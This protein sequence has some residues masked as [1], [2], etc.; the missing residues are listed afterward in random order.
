MRTRS[1]SQRPEESESGSLASASKEAVGK[2]LKRASSRKGSKEKGQQ[3]DPISVEESKFKVEEILKEKDKGNVGNAVGTISNKGEDVEV[4]VHR[5][6]NELEWEDGNILASESRESYSHDSEKEITVELTDFP[7]TTQRKTSRRATAEEKELA[8][9]VHKVHLLCLLSR[10]RLVDRVCNDPLIQASLLSLLPPSLLEIAEI[11]KLTGSTLGP[12]VKWFHNNF[13]LRSHDVDRGSFKSNLAFA[14]ESRLGTAEEVTALSVALFRALNLT[15]RFLSVL[16]VASLKP[17]RDVLGCSNPDSP[18]L[19]TNIFSSAVAS[20]SDQVSASNL[21]HPLPSSTCS[22]DI[23]HETLA[24][25]KH[26]KK[27]GRPIIKK[28]PLKGSASTTGLDIV[29]SGDSIANKL[30]SDKLESLPAKFPVGSKRKGDAEFE[31]QLEMAL[32]ATAAGVS[33]SNLGSHVDELSGSSLLPSPPSKK[34]KKP[35]LHQHESVITNHGSSSAVWSQKL[36]PPTYWAEVYCSG[37]TLNGRWVHVDAVNG[38]VDGESNVEAAAA[39]GRKPLKYV[40]AFSGGGAK[41]VTRRYCMHW[42]KIAPRRVNSQWWDEVLAP[43][44]LLESDATGGMIRMEASNLKEMGSELPHQ[45]CLNPLN[46]KDDILEGSYKKVATD[47]SSGVATRNSLEDMELDTR[48]LTEPLPTNQLAYKNH[49]LYVLE[50]WLTKYQFLHPKGPVLGHCSGHPVYPRSCVQ[51]LQTR[52]KWLRE[53]LQ[54]IANEI[55]AKVV[56]HSKKF[57]KMQRSEDVSFPGEDDG[58]ATMELFGKWQ[59]EPLSLPCAKNGVVPKNERG[60]VDVWS[61]KC[62]PPGTVHLKFPRLVPVVRRLEIDFAPAM[63][64]FEFRNGRSFPIFEGIVVCSEFK[65]AILAA[66]AEEED[67]REAEEKRRQESQA[68]S[69]WFQLLS[70]IVTRQR[71]QNSY[72]DS[73]SSYEPNNPRIEEENNKSFDDMLQRESEFG[74][75]Q[76]AATGMSIHNHAHVFPIEDQSFDEESFVRTKRCPCGFSVQVEEL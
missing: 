70:S 51:I 64:G 5:D 36:G 75:A 27:D 72:V 11:P 21:L 29:I 18:R 71:L 41:D 54:V 53:G 74:L 15:T 42:Y 38:I 8:E 32:S 58:Q 30:C 43:L 57:V 16:D 9:L 28:S 40:V 17:D 50:R 45:E 19:D 13:Q 61:E 63:V 52:Q 10:G 25:G 39:A 6:A 62:L 7:S 65:D 56:K 55:P 60:Q 3:E 46:T 23:S 76:D 1:Q 49:H 22:N 33:A 44:K 20:S 4:S 73:S 14:L 67:R 26:H 59:V 66:Y 68:V 35:S 34:L 48:A 12:L 24:R 69:R 2:L 47:L 31:L 37:E